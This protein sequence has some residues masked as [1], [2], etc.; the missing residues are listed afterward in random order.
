MFLAYAICNPKNI[1]KVNDGAVEEI[2]RLAKDGVASPELE[3]AKKGFLE[4]M[5]VQRSSDG[6]IAGMLREALYLNRTMQWEADLE[7]K[8][9]A[10]SVA[11]VNQ[12]L[13]A[14]LTPDR[15]VIIR[16]GDFS[17]NANGAKQ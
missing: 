7:K 11:D 17:K 2:T 15:L 3:E 16:A 12:A 5:K 10:L 14:H 4:Q 9:A 13:S 8:I 1:D 6:R